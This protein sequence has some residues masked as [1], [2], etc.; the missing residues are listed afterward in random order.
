MKDNVPTNLYN[1]FHTSLLYHKIR[2]YQ[3]EDEQTGSSVNN[4]SIIINNQDLNYGILRVRYLN[5]GK[6]TNNLLK[7]DYK[8]R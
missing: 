3:E 5:N 8:I 4:N 1:H 7:H 6:L 2:T